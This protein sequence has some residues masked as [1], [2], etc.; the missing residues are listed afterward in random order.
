MPRKSKQSPDYSWI[1]NDPLQEEIDTNADGS[2]FIPIYHVE[3]KLF[4]LDTHWGTESFHFQLFKGVSNAMLV[5]SSL[6][7]VITYGGRTR[8]IVGSTT[9]FVPAD[10]DFTDSLVNSNYSGTLKSE[11]IKNAAKTI[12]KA[13]GAALNER[14]VILTPVNKSSKNGKQKPPAVKMPA[15]KHIRQEYAKAVVEGDT[16]FVKELEAAYE[17]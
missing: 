4:K 11:N 13:F 12:G 9:S 7:L 6:E 15:D 16:Q 8:R 5:Q 3:R 10:V 2:E 1:D 14:D 17:F